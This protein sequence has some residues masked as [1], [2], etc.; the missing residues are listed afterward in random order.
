MS[1]YVDMESFRRTA[2]LGDLPIDDQAATA[3][4]SAEEAIEDYCGRRFW[5]SES[6]EVRYFAGLWTGTIVDDLV[7][8]TTL[9]SDEDG[10]GTFETT[11]AATDYV[12]APYNAVAD[13]RPF[14]RLEV[15]PL[16][17]KRF[18]SHARSI[19]ITGRFGWPAVPKRVEQ[20]TILQALRWLK[21]V[22]SSPLGVEAVVIEGAPVRIRSRIDPDVEVLLAP[23]RRLAP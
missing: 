1:R 19:E 14:T 17:S 12:L 9:R 6:D 13:G 18:C 3:I 20:A 11:W 21:R 7:S 4:D 2:Q 16:G 15:A 5:Q 23:L 22:R 10:D 8:I